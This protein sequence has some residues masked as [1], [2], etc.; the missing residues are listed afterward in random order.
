MTDADVQVSDADLVCAVERD[1][2]IAFIRALRELGLDKTEPPD[3]N[4]HST[5]GLS[6]RQLQGL[7]R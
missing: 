3:H 4:R 7:D 2:R 1:S 5:I 6:W